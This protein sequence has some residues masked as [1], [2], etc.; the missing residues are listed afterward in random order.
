[1]FL[2]MKRT[3]IIQFIIFILVMAESNAQILDANTCDSLLL[4]KKEYE[5]CK[6]D[7]VYETDIINRTNYLISFTTQ[8]LPKY[9][10]K[11]QGLYSSKKLNDLFEK[12]RLV[13][14]SVS[15]QKLLFFEKDMLKNQL[16]I[17][18]KAYISSLLAFQSFKLYP[19]IYAI[20]LNDIHLQ[21]K[22]KTTKAQ[23]KN[24]TEKVDEIIGSIP[25]DLYNKVLK[26]T[27]ELAAENSFLVKR[28]VVQ[29]FNGALSESDKIKYDIVNFLIWNK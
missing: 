28:G 1:M 20:L 27:T 14:D 19:N 5:K 12:F 2:I 4:T 24:Y 15:E 11:R 23:L 22:P 13:Y 9:R 6:V 16:A 25:E 26:I 7:A 8:L 18:P 3:I 29:I 10:L 21:L 17:Q